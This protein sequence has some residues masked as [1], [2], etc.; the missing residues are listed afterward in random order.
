MIELNQWT[1][2]LLGV[3]GAVVGLL[4]CLALFKV[5]SDIT[6]TPLVFR[7]GPLKIRINDDESE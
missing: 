4:I 2:L 7:L 5:Y 6:D 3:G 1:L